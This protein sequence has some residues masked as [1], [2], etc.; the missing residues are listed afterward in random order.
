MLFLFASWAALGVLLARFWRLLGASCAAP[1]PSRGAPGGHCGLPGVSFWSF[2]GLFPK[3]PW[4]IAKTLQTLVFSMVLYGFWPPRG[5]PNRAQM[6]ARSLL[7]ASWHLLALTWRF[8][9]LSWRLAA[10][11]RSCALL[12]ASWGVLE[13]ILA[14]K[15]NLAIM[16]R[17][18][19]SKRELQARQAANNKDAKH[20][21]S[22]LVKLRG[23]VPRPRSASWRGVAWNASRA[24]G[25]NRSLETKEKS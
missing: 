16:E 19:R 7:P 22:I 17:E 9:A 23:R 14:Q 24:G 12:G 8:S 25:R 11:W 2:F 5:V 6:A 20:Q 18:A 3:T 10:S 15:G 4:K 13:A 1:G 21:Q